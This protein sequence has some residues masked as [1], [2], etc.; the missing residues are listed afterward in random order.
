MSD[1]ERE[2]PSVTTSAGE[3]RSRSRGRF[4]PTGAPP[5]WGLVRYLVCGLVVGTVV[6][7]AI[8]LVATY[9]PWPRDEE[10]KEPV[11]VPAT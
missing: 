9:L 5:A 3:A 11:P 2:Q 8:A 10:D 1:A 4:T 7:C 6:G